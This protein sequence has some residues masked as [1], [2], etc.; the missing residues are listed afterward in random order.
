MF[1]YVV[2]AALLAVAFADPEPKAKPGVL[3]A[4]P[5]VAAPLAYSAAYTS[6]L[7]G[8]AYA[9]PYVASPLAYSAGYAAPVAYSAHPAAYSAYPAAYSAYP[10]YTSPIVKYL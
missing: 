1:K 7:V 3:A 9:S 4:A 10:A 8:A 2:F 5:V 6:P